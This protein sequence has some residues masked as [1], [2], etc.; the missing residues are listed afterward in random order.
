[1][2][3]LNNLAGLV[4]SKGLH[5]R[6]LSLAIALKTVAALSCVNTTICGKSISIPFFR[7]P[8]QRYYVTSPDVVFK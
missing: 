7:W 4:V 6:S 3:L 2:N 5:A 8:S 1:M